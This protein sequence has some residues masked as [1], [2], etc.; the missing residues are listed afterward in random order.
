MD[1]TEL[2][3]LRRK[4]LSDWLEVN[5][6]AHNV[7]ERR[8]LERKVESH[9]S[10]IINGYS[11]GPRAARNMEEKLGLESGYLD[12]AVNDKTIATLS[13]FALELAKMFD[14]VTGQ[15]PRTIAYNSATEAILKVL[16]EHA[17]QPTGKQVLPAKR[18]KQHA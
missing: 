11:F 12:G 15:I 9:I 3:A 13:P 17:P 6:G 14:Q 2:Q 18:K 1:E 7:C 5:G 16:R 8:K 4:R 10:Q